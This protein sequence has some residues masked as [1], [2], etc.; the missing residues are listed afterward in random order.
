MT[1]RCYENLP[2]WPAKSPNVSCLPEANHAN[3]L[4]AAS[5][6]MKEGICKPILLGNDGWL[7]RVI[8]CGLS[9]MQIYHLEIRAEDR[10][11]RYAQLLTEKRQREGM[12][13]AEAHEKM[14]D[15][16]Y[17]GMMMVEAGENRRLHHST[18]SSMQ[19]LYR[20]RRGYRYTRR[21]QTFRVMHIMNTK[22]GTYFLADTLINPETN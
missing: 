4:Q 13:Y 18:Y 9:L 20:L 12:T 15:R 16:N 6:A 1:T 17:F 19:R 8:R 2:K 5:T 21:I 14:F 7:G 10:R 3:M 22:C 11:I